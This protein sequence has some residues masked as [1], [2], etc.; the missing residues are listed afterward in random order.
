MSAL[1][2]PLARRG[3]RP[4]MANLRRVLNAMLYVAASRFAWGALPICI[5]PVSTGLRYFYA[6]RDAGLFEANITVLVI[7]LPQIE[8][9]DATASGRMIDSQSVKTTESRGIS[10]LT[11]ATFRIEMAL[12]TCWPHSA[13]G[14]SWLRQVIADG[15]HAGKK[16]RSAL[17]GTG[18]HR[19]NP[20]DPAPNPKVLS[21]LTNF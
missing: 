17:V 9:H 7:N 14:L 6:W 1:F 16:L 12:A 11:R 10:G 15:G 21:N 8:R 13:R 2:A 5:R 20:H 18:L 3:D 4:R 19:L